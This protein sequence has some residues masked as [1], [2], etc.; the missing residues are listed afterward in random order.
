MA[1]SFHRIVSRHPNLYGTSRSTS[2]CTSRNVSRR[3]S[4]VSSTGATEDASV[5]GREMK[6]SSHDENCNVSLPKATIVAVEE[7]SAQKTANW[8]ESV[9]SQMDNA[10]PLIDN[11]F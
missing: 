11:T 3:N 10:P 6:N 2:R 5:D 7:E 9:T 4:D 8:L 1:L